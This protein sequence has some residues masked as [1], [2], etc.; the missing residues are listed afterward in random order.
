MNLNETQQDQL[1]EASLK[2]G[3][4][5]DGVLKEYPGQPMHIDVQPNASLV[6]RRPYL[7]HQVHLTTFEKGFGSLVTDWSTVPSQRYGVGTA[8]FY[9]TQKRWHSK[10]GI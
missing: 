9:N 6:Y 4:L 7:V 5:F 10:M 8:N 3:K 1:K 2:Y